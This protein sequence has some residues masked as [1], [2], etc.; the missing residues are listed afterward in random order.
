[1]KPSAKKVNIAELLDKTNEALRDLDFDGQ[2]S[3]HIVVDPNKCESGHFIL[4]IV[5]DCSTAFLVPVGGV[6][7]TY[8]AVEIVY[9]F[10]SRKKELFESRGRPVR[11]FDYDDYVSPDYSKT[12]SRS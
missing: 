8:D 6:N 9:D 3:A 2:Y 12:W 11:E 10:V 5:Q 4:E 1:M 7:S